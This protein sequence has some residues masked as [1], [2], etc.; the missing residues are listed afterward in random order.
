MGREVDFGEFGILEFPDEYSDVDITRYLQSSEFKSLLQA[1][2]FEYEE[3]DLSYLKTIVNSFKSGAYG[4]QQALVSDA[5]ATGLLDEET[6]AKVITDISKGTLKLPIPASLKEWQE[7]EGD[8]YTSINQILK[9]PIELP[10]AIAAEGAGNLQTTLPL[11]AAGAG[12]G[13]LA[14]N[15]PGAFAGGGGGVALGS[16][17]AESGGQLL[18]V[19]AKHGVDIFDQDA[20]EAAFKNKELMDIAVG[21]GIV[22]GSV[23]AAMDAA[24]YFTGG[25]LLSQAA[26]KALLDK[27]LVGFGE[28]GIQAAG[29]MAG[30]AIGTPLATGE[31]ASAKAILS[32]GIGEVIPG[33]GEITIGTAYRAAMRDWKAP[34]IT[35]KIDLA[36]DDVG[37]VVVLGKDEE[38]NEQFAQYLGKTWIEGEEVALIKNE[39]GAVDTAP[40]GSVQFFVKPKPR[41]PKKTKRKDGEEATDTPSVND[42]EEVSKPKVAGPPDE[43]QATDPVIMDLYEEINELKQAKDELINKGLD[44]ADETGR[45]QANNGIKEL[46]NLITRKANEIKRLSTMS[47]EEIAEYI[48]DPLTRIRNEYGVEDDAVAERI[49]AVEETGIDPKFIK[50]LP[51]FDSSAIQNLVDDYSKHLD[52]QDKYGKGYKAEIREM[53]RLSRALSAK[54]RNTPRD[55]DWHERRANRNIKK[56]IAR[57]QEIYDMRKRYNDLRKRFG[58]NPIKN[59]DRVSPN[60]IIKFAFKNGMGMAE[61]PRFMKAFHASRSD[62]ERF[63]LGYEKTGEGAMMFGHGLY[64]G[65][66]DVVKGHYLKKFNEEKRYFKELDASSNYD[67]HL[68]FD[69]IRD[70]EAKRSPAL[71]Q[72]R[73]PADVLVE[74]L[75]HAKTI[76]QKLHYAR[77]IRDRISET[78][79]NVNNEDWLPSN[80]WLYDA[81]HGAYSDMGVIIDELKDG[82]ADIAEMWPDEKAILYEVD[83]K[84]TPDNH[85][86][87]DQPIKD[88][89]EAVRQAF[90]RLGV[91]DTPDYTA[92]AEEAVNEH[93]WTEIPLLDDPRFTG[94]TR[95]WE[96]S[97]GPRSIFIREY[98]MSDPRGQFEYK[99]RASD[100]INFGFNTEFLDTFEEAVAAGENQ[101]LI[102]AR[103]TRMTG[104]SAYYQLAQNME[105]NIP[106]EELNVNGK[107]ISSDELGEKKASMALKN[108]GIIGHRFAHGLVRKRSLAENLA[109]EKAWNFVIYDE[110]AV[111]ILRKSEKLRN[112]QVNEP[113]DT[114]QQ[115]QMDELYQR[116]RAE[117]D[118]MGLQ[119]V[120]L[121]L[122]KTLFQV[123]PKTGVNEMVSGRYMSNTIDVAFNASNPLNTLSHEAFHHLFEMGA[124]TPEEI[125]LLES[126]LKGWR[127]TY[128]IDRD[129]PELSNRDKNEEAIAFA[130]G[131]WYSGSTTPAPL[132]QNLFNK[133]LKIWEALGNFFKGLGYKT[134]EDVFN[135]IKGGRV[136]A[137]SY[138]QQEYRRSAA[139][140]YPVNNPVRSRRNQVPKDARNIAKLAKQLRDGP[141]D[142]AD[143]KDIS[144][145]ARILNSMRHVASHNRDVGLWM[146]FVE[147]IR[148][149]RLSIVERATQTLH[150]ISKLTK[151]DRLIF[152]QAAEISQQAPGK[153]RRNKNGDIIFVAQADGAGI[154]SVL[155]EGDVII[156]SGRLADAYEGAQKTMAN[157]LQELKRGYMASVAPEFLKLKEYGIVPME[158]PISVEAIEE[159]GFQDLKDLVD[160]LEGRK[161]SAQ[162]GII[163]DVELLKEPDI[164]KHAKQLQKDI[165]NLNELIEIFSGIRD[166]I[167]DYMNFSRFDYF[168]H[169]RYG[170]RYIAVLNEAGHTIH[171]EQVET[172]A[173]TGNARRNNVVNKRIAELKQVYNSPK[174]KFKTGVNTLDALRNGM[175]FK[176]GEETLELAAGFL[177][178]KDK[179]KMFSEIRNLINLESSKR[180]FKAHMRPRKNTPG[181]STDYYRNMAQYIATAANSAVQMRYG[182]GLN[183]AYAATQQE[184]NGPQ[185]QRF[186]R[187]AHEYVTSPQEEYQTYRALAFHWYLGMNFSSA[188]LQAI[189]LV[190]FTGPYLSQFVNSAK[191]L[192]YLTVAAKDATKLLAVSSRSKGRTEGVGY[193]DLWIDFTKAP[194]DV[195]AALKRAVE[196]G[197]VKQHA[198]LEEIGISSGKDRFYQV[199]AYNQLKGLMSAPF[200]TVETFSRMTAFIAAYRMSQDA[201]VRDN[202]YNVL[203]NNQLFHAQNSLA[204]LKD[205]QVD[206]YLFSKFVVDETF[207]LYGK[208]NRPAYQR[209]V[210]AAVFQF[211]SYIHQT[212]EM[213]W[214]MMS[215]QGIEGKKAFAKVMIAMF[216]TAGMMGLPGADDA[217]DIYDWAVKN[218]T[219]IDPIVKAELRQMMY[220]VTNGNQFATTMATEGLFNALGLDIQRRISMDIPGSD[221]FMSAIGVRGSAEDVLG[222]PGSM[223]LGNFKNFFQIA[224]EGRMD[225]A[226]AHAMPMFLKNIYT[227]YG[228]YNSPVGARTARGEQVLLPEELSRAGII[229]KSFGFAPTQVRHARE[230][231]YTQRRV[232]EAISVAKERF[233]QR[234]VDAYYDQ[235]YAIRKDDSRSLEAATMRLNDIFREIQTHNAQASMENQI[236]IDLTTIRNRVMMRL[237]PLSDIKSMR[238]HARPR[239]FEIEDLYGE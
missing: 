214:R 72:K 228:L 124:F 25:L 151:E 232:S 103:G 90:A 70:E 230:K 11:M 203:G 47:P 89:S 227:A 194:P 39:N 178:G 197:I 147:R 4:N 137:R 74:E 149:G 111:E 112:L 28:V 102:A 156:L 54:D 55:L 120:H 48:A 172:P 140:P 17:F 198:V 229:A 199:G 50:E 20:V 165:E 51:G 126:N 143:I 213:I 222:L 210:G 237:N 174:F 30:E 175:N 22:K 2:G 35:T 99:Y 180:G 110:D 18:E 226:I 171:Y 221:V 141:S 96:I 134:A 86:V 208:A 64:F 169:L 167:E 34:P 162:L 78:M 216:L 176:A 94:I 205:G 130:F 116:M 164:K 69:Y 41:K 122:E 33:V 188:A 145:P 119:D 129:Y 80:Q 114:I 29:G 166:S 59:W 139:E 183:E 1:E 118:R 7:T 190:Q 201:Q 16:F 218:I 87:W 202:I 160:T 23:V 91:L 66:D 82:Q 152:N 32:E 132:L 61:M 185:I 113:I 192:K 62:H 138:Y 109:D 98:Q 67:F 153:Y 182:R 157:I 186:A 84:L 45:E 5:V 101:L 95:M 193:N 235:F 211:Q 44:A 209:G 231:A 223:I 127:E 220:D 131:D 65:P 24:S 21:Q 195:K 75:R 8:F 40:L 191:A 63:A 184:W 225:E 81:L 60:E 161:L 158:S 115:E 19:F 238:K 150:P 125:A 159:M 133:A 37:R 31:P 15:L 92:E 56:S 68:V 42:A 108:E 73:V 146:T 85:F 79:I 9:S 93:L 212:L 76:K 57:V 207:G 142:V 121:N 107:R 148:S 177:H 106:F 58:L 173:Y 135:D 26:K 10:L 71:T 117:L 236:I 97:A 187:D 100:G 36:D 189:S 104:E 217:A 128:N 12:A 215:Q 168:P 3:P 14:G 123:N 163:N 49:R 136:A 224:S 38:G 77:L 170:D 52:L 53:G 83:L 200:N 155:K 239:G 233:S 105:R 204:G 219:G 43:V 181:Y 196:E 46:D 6:G 234:L 88:Q 13:Y 179:G 154:N 27:I 206:P 144:G